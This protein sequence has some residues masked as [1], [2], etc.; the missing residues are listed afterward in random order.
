MMKLRLRE[1]RLYFALLLLAAAAA[2]IAGCV[3]HTKPSDT[4]WEFAQP[5]DA[6]QSASGPIGN[7]ATVYYQCCGKWPASVP[8]LRS[9]NCKDTAKHQQITN[10][11]AQVPWGSVRNVAF[12][13]TPDGRLA[14]SLNFASRTISTNGNSVTFG[15]ENITEMLD[16]PKHSKK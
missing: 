1:T 6:R 11:L 15:G 12:K 5:E 7:A 3:T 8:E 9:L 16:V 4:D 2:V 13:T 14:I 10:Y